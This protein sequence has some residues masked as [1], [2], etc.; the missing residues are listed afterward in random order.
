MVGF[1]EIVGAALL[2]AVLLQAFAGAGGILQRRV[3]EARRQRVALSLFRARVAADLVTIRR[4]QERRDAAWEG[5]RKFRID[6]KV[7][8]ADDICSF[9]FVAHD[10]MPLSRYR[11][12]QFLTFQLRVPGQ[13]Q[14]VVRCYSLSDSAE[15][16]GYYRCTIKR[17]PPP[18]DNPDAPAGI[19]SSFFH[20]CNEGD[21][22]DVRAPSGNFCLDVNST[23][24]VVLIG[25]GI[26]LTP[27]LSMLNAICDAKNPRETWF[28]YGVRNRREHAMYEHLRQIAAKH[29]NVN[30]VVCYSD[31]TESCIEGKD[32]DV[33]GWVSVD[34]FKRMLPSNN[35][36]FYICGPPAMME[37]VTQGLRDWGVPAEDVHFEAFG[38]ATVKRQAP[39]A[40]E[41]MPATAIKISL[42]RSRK[43]VEWQPAD[44]SILDAAE[45]HGIA[46]ASGCRAGSCGTCET[47]VREGSVKY[48]KD[49]GYKPN[50]GSCLPC[51]AVPLSPLVLDA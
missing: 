22:I 36:E 32:Y 38:P 40:L 44:G 10:Q 49:T 17:I 15:R 30:L 34:L 37:S 27:V 9:Y 31:P 16:P 42:S 25:G 3:F 51:V 14:P 23:R 7:M 2:G 33:R 43:S 28:F 26:G 39:V 4:E 12:G 20:G 6:R 41:G 8:E 29:D 47:A 11:P 46:M 19:A 50:E 21:L 48:L 13:P 45:K 1:A 24:P 5:Y 18:R 35:Y